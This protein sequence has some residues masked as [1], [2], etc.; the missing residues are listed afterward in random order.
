MELENFIKN[1][2]EAKNYIIFMQRILILETNLKRNLL[3]N[4]YRRQ[5]ETSIFLMLI[6][7]MNI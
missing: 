2:K 4:L 1:E 7:V 3:K 6:P 5:L